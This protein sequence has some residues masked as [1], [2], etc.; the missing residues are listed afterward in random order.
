M[1]KIIFISDIP[2]IVLVFTFIL[3]VIYN[4]K[5]GIICDPGYYKY[6]LFLIGE[7]FYFISNFFS[8]YENYL[9]CSLHFLFKN[10]GISLI[11]LIFY[12][13]NSFSFLIGIQFNKE[14][15][16]ELEH[17]QTSTFHNSFRERSSLFL[18][19]IFFEKESNETNKNKIHLNNNPVKLKS[20]SIEDKNNSIISEENIQMKNELQKKLN[21]DE[22]SERKKS[23][24]E[25][26]V[27]FNIVNKKKKHESTTLNTFRNSILKMKSSNL[28]TDSESEEEIDNYNNLFLLKSIT[29]AKKTFLKLLV[30]YPI[31]I[32][33]TLLIL[34]ISYIYY[35]KKENGDENVI[36]KYIT[37]NRDGYWT[38]KYNLYYI[39]LVYNSLHIFVMII[40]L[41]KGKQI[42]NYKFIYK[43]TQNITY[44][45]YIA[46]ILGPTVNVNI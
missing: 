10:V 34:I 17:V 44:S 25:N 38:V 30:G 27:I 24:E 26:A 28:T 18:K 4:R 8:T 22:S 14:D 11:L 33:T 36:K 37:Q 39:D 16:K 7:I 9:E 2:V 21:I 6:L 43:C 13:F 42:I 3:F 46:I 40:I 31:F 41:I 5:Q 20:Q 32:L 23:L 35:K 1:K 15:E 19:S 45:S 12:I 29:C